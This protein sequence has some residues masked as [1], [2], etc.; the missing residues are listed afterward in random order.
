MGKGR[1]KGN[2]INC[3]DIEAIKS[4][5]EVAVNAFAERWISMPKFTTDC[6]VM[7]V[8]QL[9]DAMGLR[10]TFENGDPWPKAEQLLIERGFR[11]HW[12]GASRVM[13][14]RERDDYVPDDGWEEGE[15][16]N[17]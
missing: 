6:E 10:A 7:D 17:G 13:F 3:T 2:E 8:R 4:N 14:L 1:D 9:R 12:I 16:V 5:A 11:W 15:E